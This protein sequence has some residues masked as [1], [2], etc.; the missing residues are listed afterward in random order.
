MDEWTA[1]KILDLAPDASSRKA[2]QPLGRAAAWVGTWR[3]GWLAWGEIKGSG[4]A[5]YLTALSLDGPVFKCSCPSRKFPCKH[6]LG[7]FLVLAAGGAAEGEPPDWVA[8][9]QAKRGA[10][11]APKAAGDDKPIDAK[12]QDKRRRQRE[13][14]VEAGIGELELWMRDLVRRGLAGARSEPYAFWDRMGARLVDAQA[15]GLARRVRELPGR[16]AAG[17]DDAAVL[18]LGRL[19]LLVQGWRR[20]DALPEALRAELRA[21]VGFPV[22]AEDLALLPGVVDHWTVAAQVTEQEEALQVRSTWLCGA[23]SSGAGG[24]VAQ[25]LDFS[26]GGRPLP[27]APVPGQAFRGEVVFHPGA[28]G[29]R[30]VIRSQEGAEAAPLAGAGIGA[31]LDGVAE[32]LGRVPWLEEWPMTLRGVRFARASGGFAL[33]EG[34][35]ALP[36]ADGPAVL[37]FVAVAGGEAA[38]VF[39]VWDGRALRVLAVGMG[40]RL[41]QPSA[42]ALHLVRRAA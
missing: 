33:M 12:A 22:S 4:A 9:W 29:L 3:Q 16:L 30:G 37:P 14:K 28:A 23:G 11:A 32:A 7:L 27:A 17:G 31:A 42:S 13:A 40:A 2:G 41:Y 20:Q 35:H 1:P 21:A 10:A 39:G 15:P 26:A 36:V 5:P 34:G 19:T 24:R 18:A 6:G 8:Q 38:D 25:V